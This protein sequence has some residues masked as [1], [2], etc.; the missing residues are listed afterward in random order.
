MTVSGAG[1]QNKADS[2]IN[3]F[4]IDSLENLIPV[5]G[6]MKEVEPVVSLPLPCYPCDSIGLFELGFHAGLQHCEKPKKAVFKKPKV[7]ISS[8]GP[9]VL[10]KDNMQYKF[11]I[12]NSNPDSVQL[13]NDTVTDQIPDFKAAPI[14]MEP[15]KE[16]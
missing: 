5:R 12:R 8:N 15:F 6:I 13:I 9:A 3:E 10:D 4:R 16:K 7:L 11:P 14:R 2:K 1:M